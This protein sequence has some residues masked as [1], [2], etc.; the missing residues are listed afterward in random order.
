MMEVSIIR[1]V[2]LSMDE[3]MKYEV[4][5][6]FA[7]HPT[8]NKQ[9]AALTLGCTVRHINRMLKGYKEQLKDQ[10]KNA[11]SQK[12]VNQIQTNKYYRMLDG[13]GLQVHYRKGTK[14]MYIQAFDGKQYCCMNDKD[15]Y[16]LEEIPEHEA[17]SKIL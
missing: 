4:I 12:E 10:K 2:D 9:R 3:Q 13:Y 6:S 11:K 7:N 8:P 14:V 17:K 15:I 5:K 16:I 1:K